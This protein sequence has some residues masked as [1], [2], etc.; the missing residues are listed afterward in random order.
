M[1]D[2]QINNLSVNLKQAG[3][4]VEACLK[5]KLVPM[6]TGSPALGKSSLI[7]QIAEKFNLKLIDLRLAQ[8]DPTDLLG[9]PNI[10][11]NTGR[12]SYYPMDTFP[13][14]G[15]PLPSKF[16]EHGNKI[17]EYAGWIL[18]LD[19]LTSA[20]RSVQAAAYKLVLDRMTGM[21]RLHP[22]LLMVGAGNREGDGAIVEPM[23]TALQSRLVHIDVILDVN[24]WLEWAMQNGIDHRITD[25]VK[26]K[27]D[28]L[29][30]FKAD[31]T[32]MTYASPRT[33]EFANRLIAGKPSVKQDMLN[34]LGGC[35]SEGIAREFIGFCSIYA[36][37]PTLAQII[38]NP[39][40]T[41]VPDEP[42]VL[43][44]LTGSLANHA[45]AK[46]LDDMYKYILRLPVEFQIITL[47]ETIR[48][49]KELVST[50]AI[51]K[52]LTEQA[53]ELV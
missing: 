8:C 15:D 1:S 42:S 37:L 36:D 22:K 32:D 24:C 12:A 35:I 38:A 51:Q 20:N 17:G 52:W 28:M 23:S 4:M 6:M 45:D 29:Y 13:L 18:F 11:K 26:F 27:P 47:R 9:F 14:E 5:A 34:I 46:N 10:D 7:A 40:G 2:A 25:Y 48:R 41:V 3:S 33:W 31:H 30:T 50:P 39:E 43:Y 19:E 49:K 53:V 21:H 16:D 44:A